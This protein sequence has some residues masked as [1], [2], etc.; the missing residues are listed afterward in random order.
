MFDG[1]ARKNPPTATRQINSVM[2]GLA[3]VHQSRSG[4]RGA[5]VASAG[6]DTAVGPRRWSAGLA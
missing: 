5:A 4:E 1:S 3:S 2:P 6:D